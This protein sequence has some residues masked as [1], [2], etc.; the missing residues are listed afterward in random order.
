MD[1]NT[2]KKLKN[3]RDNYAQKGDYLKADKINEQIKF[4]KEQI[5]SIPKFYTLN[6]EDLN[7]DFENEYNDIDDYFKYK[8]I[9]FNKEAKEKEEK[10][11][12]EQ[13]K[14][15]ENYINHL[16]E[17]I[18]LKAKYSK[19]LIELK[20]KE[21][22]C[23]KNDKFEEAQYYKKLCNKI[24]QKENKNYN[25]ERNQKIDKLI[26]LFKEKQNKTYDF[27]IQK[28]QREFNEIIREKDDR[29]KYILSKYKNM[30]NKKFKIENA[31]FNTITSNLLSN[32]IS[33]NPFNS[34]SKSTTDN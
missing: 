12:D 14:E 9:D 17:T 15:L 4:I 24:E 7:N 20:N 32:C 10:L 33:E 27:L 8:I 22:N 29:I 23:A 25:I 2:L 11:K 3:E 16:N 13:E 26:K 31:D 18:P 34:L 21:L 6:T 28:L 30:K 1:N 19:N 5:K